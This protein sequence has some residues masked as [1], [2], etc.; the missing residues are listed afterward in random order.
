M[1]FVK[2]ETKELFIDGI[3]GASW[4][5]DGVT[6]AMV[7]EALGSMSGRATIRINSPGGC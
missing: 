2:S 7:G 5:G 6:A 4:T 3:I 1:I